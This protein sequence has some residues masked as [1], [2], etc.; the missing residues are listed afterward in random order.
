MVELISLILTVG[1][2]VFMMNYHPQNPYCD[3]VDIICF[4]TYFMVVGCALVLSIPHNYLY[5]RKINKINTPDQLLN[6]FRKKI[7]YEKIC[8]LVP[9]IV[10]MAFNIYDDFRLHSIMGHTHFVIWF[11]AN[12]IGIVLC[13]FLVFKPEKMQYNDEEMIVELEY[14]AEKY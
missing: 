1:V 8:F 2:I 10:L 5:I 6:L 11:L 3:D 13:I 9:L 14:L 12:V 7:R 4:F